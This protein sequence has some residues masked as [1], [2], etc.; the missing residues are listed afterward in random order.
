MNQKRKTLKKVVGASAVVAL[1]PASW[2]KPLVNSVFLPAHA[3][4]SSDDSNG[5]IILGKDYTINKRG[6][7]S[8]LI[9]WRDSSDQS[10]CIPN[11]LETGTTR[12][13]LVFDVTRSG[14]S[15]GIFFRYYAISGSGDAFIKYTCSPNGARAGPFVLKILNLSAT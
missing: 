5:E 7:S 9:A 2:T 13:D 10:N 6:A 12:G 8:G 11:I 1:V 4:T 15:A 14:G 3:Q